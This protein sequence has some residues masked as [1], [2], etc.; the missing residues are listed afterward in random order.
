[1]T[2]HII[3]HVME[4][5]LLSTYL[6]MIRRNLYFAPISVKNKAYLATVRPIIEYASMC[7]SPSSAQLIRKLEM[8]QHSAA[9]F[10][11]NCYPKKGHYDEFSVSNLIEKLGWVSLEKRREEA[12]LTMAFKIIN[13][14]V[15]INPNTLP[16][17]TQQRPSR[18]C[19]ETLVGNK[20]QLIEPD[21]R[22]DV[23]KNSFFLKVPSLWNK[24]I[25]SKQAEAPNVE[26]FKHYFR[27]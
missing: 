4:Q 9:K 15:I 13:N 2:C 11:M 3:S 21:S 19:N 24:T 10:V 5:G 12:Q 8:V 25:T 26:S 22:L 17:K 20:H 18:K 27:K 7:W 6:N 16:K 14:L 1:M 23:T